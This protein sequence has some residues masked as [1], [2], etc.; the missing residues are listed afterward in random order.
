MFAYL[1]FVKSTERSCFKHCNMYLSF[2]K[3]YPGTDAY[4]NEKVAVHKK[5]E[6]WSELTFYCEKFQSSE[7]YELQFL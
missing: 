6:H 4:Y 3:K 7:Q 2:V 1:L 5:W